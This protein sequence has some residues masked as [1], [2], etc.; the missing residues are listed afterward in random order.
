MKWLRWIGLILFLLHAVSFGMMGRFWAVLHVAHVSSVTLDPY[1]DPYGPKPM[2]PMTAIWLMVAVSLVFFFLVAPP[3]YFV[4][5]KWPRTT[6]YLIV[7]VVAGYIVLPI[8]F[9]MIT[10]HHNAQRAD[11]LKYLPIFIA[12]CAVCVM[13]MLLGTTIISLVDGISARTPRAAVSKK[14]EK[15]RR[16]RTEEELPY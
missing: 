3:L 5:R 14:S 4:G 1:A 12:N 16:K 6:P 7:I 13:G 10:P 15:R 9:S 8:L 2:E 11:Q